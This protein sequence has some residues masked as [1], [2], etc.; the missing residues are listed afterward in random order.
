MESFGPSIAVEDNVLDA[1]AEYLNFN[2][3]L[4]NLSSPLRAFLPT[5]VV[6]KEF[7]NATLSADVRYNLFTDYIK[8]EIVKDKRWVD[9]K[10]VE[11][12]FIPVSNDRHQF[13]EVLNLKTND[14]C[15]L[16]SRTIFK[17]EAKKPKKSCKKGS[18]IEN[19]T[20]STI[21]HADFGRYLTSIGHTKASAIFHAG[22][23]YLRMQCQTNS[24]AANC[25][26][27]AMRHMETF[28]GKTREKCECGLDIEGRKLTTQINKL[29]VKYAA[30]ILLFGCNIHLNKVG[31]LVNGKQ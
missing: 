21:L 26:V 5:F 15:V 22:L 6:T 16:D 19:D 20:L 18:R 14:V 23:N 13:V 24:K 31:D 4:H 12:V 9:F 7:R 29:R 10:D 3:R 8:K 30:K 28:M 25:G 27:Y 17:D 11:M 1:W 2:E